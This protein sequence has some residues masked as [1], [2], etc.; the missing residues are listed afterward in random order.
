M[1]KKNPLN[2]NALQ[3]KTLTLFQ[4]FARMEGYSKPAEEPGHVMI[5]RMPHAHGNH[6]HLGNYLLDAKDASGLSNENA[7]VA[8]QRKGLV[9]SFWP[10][11]CQITP[12]GLAYDTGLRDEILREG[13]HH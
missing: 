2:L 10:M 5:T 8:L 13:G 12:E 11:G 3:L 4:E 7:W 6:F 1:P 9:K